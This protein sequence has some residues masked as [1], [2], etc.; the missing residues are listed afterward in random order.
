MKSGKC[1]RYEELISGVLYGR[2]PHND[3][4]KNYRGDALETLETFG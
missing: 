1:C 3:L 2:W 4:S